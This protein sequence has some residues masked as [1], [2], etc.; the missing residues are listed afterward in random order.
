[1]K[2]NF[3]LDVSSL[4]ETNSHS[5]FIHIKDRNGKYIFCNENTLNACDFA[6]L[7][8]ILNK[9]DFEIPV[10]E[11]E[12]N[13]YISRHQMVLSNNAPL[14]SQHYATLP[15]KKYNLFGIKVPLTNKTGIT[16]GVLS[17]DTEID[18]VND[19]MLFL[20]QINADVEKNNL[21]HRQA[22]CLYYLTQGKSAKEIARLLGLSPR[23]VEYYLNIQKKK[24]NCKDRSELVSK[25]LK[26]PCIQKRL[27]SNP[28]QDGTHHY[29]QRI[30]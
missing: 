27:L 25:A 20:P 28:A 8:D 29:P 19:L 17:I 18:K 6:S 21:T 1:M 13:L 12:A 7:K 23:T 26:T 15:D 10:T 4:L 9:T 16:T 24:F 3:N 14:F 30:Y 22:D 5:F 2:Y 11:E